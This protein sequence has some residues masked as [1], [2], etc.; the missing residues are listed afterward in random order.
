MVLT[1]TPLF[2]VIKLLV[3]PVVIPAF[4]VINPDDVMVFVDIEVPVVNAFAVSAVPAVVGF[5]FCC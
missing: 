2:A 1:N 3:V 5:Q 4:A